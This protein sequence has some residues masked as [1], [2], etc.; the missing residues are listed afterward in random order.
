MKPTYLDHNATT[1]LD[2]RVLEAM[3]P[4]LTEHFGNASSIH[5]FGAPAKKGVDE[6]R[7]I[8]AAHLGCEERE[9]IFT[10]GATES[11]N[12]VLFGVAEALRRRGSH[13]VTSAIEHPAV[14]SA[15]Q[16]L[17]RAG[18]EITRVKPDSDGVIHAD[19]VREALR[20]DTILVSI[21]FANNE[22]GAVQ[23]ISEIGRVVKERGIQFHTDAVQ[24]AGKFPLNVD[25][26]GVD[27]MSLSGHK[28]YGPKGVGVLYIR[29]GSFIRSHMVGGHHEFNRRAGTE[30]VPGIVGFAKALQLS[31]DLMSEENERLAAMR[32]RLQARLLETIPNIY[33]TSQHAPRTPNTLHVLFHFVEGEGLMMKLSMLHGI[34]VSTGSACTSGTLEP[35]HVLGAMGISKQLGNSGIRISLGRGNRMDEIDTIADAFAKEVGFLRDMSPL[36]DAFA[37]GRLS[38]ADLLDYQ[39]WLTTPA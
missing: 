23:P 31:Q 14:L 34:G 7:A 25:E 16:K 30:N 2:P 13:I 37:D 5:Q 21:M 10:S 15:V 3:M 20:E 27:F 38:D 1:P 22:T 18:F 4:Y 19:T 6:A 36:Q 24:A 28:I 32:D 11:D 35:S 39:T 29:R 26:L 33:I 9:V 8:V 12:H 17:E